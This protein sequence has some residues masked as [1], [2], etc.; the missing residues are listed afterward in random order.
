MKTISKLLFIFLL[1][2]SSS[3]YAAS[4][5]DVTGDDLLNALTDKT[6]KH[7]SFTLYYHSDGTRVVKKKDGKTINDKWT[8][9]RDDTIY[10]IE[11]EGRDK[12]CAKL[13]ANGKKRRFE[14]LE[15]P[16]TGKTWNVKIE[17]G[18]PE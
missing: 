1:I 11:R 4:W 14:A 17:D 8:L 6:W 16:S 12:L 2:T 9:E 7:K 13:Q 3:S 5:E 15:G 10:C 18:V